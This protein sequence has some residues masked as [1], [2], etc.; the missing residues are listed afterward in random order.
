[1]INRR[2]KKQ[3]YPHQQQKTPQYP[4]SSSSAPPPPELAAFSLA[5]AIQEARTT[6]LPQQQQQQQRSKSNRVILPFFQRNKNPSQASL[7]TNTSFATA[8]DHIRTSSE[9]Q[10]I[11]PSAV[12]Y[13]VDSSDEETQ[14]E[15]LTFGNDPLS[16]LSRTI[17]VT[18][19]PTE[20]SFFD[21]NPEET[22]TNTSI[23]MST[24]VDPTPVPEA[25][26]AAITTEE[27]FVETSTDTEP[28]FD[29][30]QH[31]YSH[32]KGIW[33]WGKTIPV[34]SNVLTLTETSTAKVLDLTIHMDLPAIDQDVVSPHAKK[35]DDIVITPAI[36]A[37]WGIISPAVVKGEEMIVKPVL[38]EV[39]PR[40]LGPLGFLKEKK[41]EVVMEEKKNEIDKSVNPEVV[42]V[43]LN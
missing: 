12:S 13:F 41:V 8:N 40:I 22:T 7:A 31:I 39:V 6:S 3:R 35:L 30:A 9:Q 20:I 21:N 33:A 38:S 10:N 23:I 25:T 18:T 42:P 36:C 16:V 34:L 26:P 19:K 28:H 43:A 11:T 15:S 27:T 17:D 14:D 32:T 1:M 24:V 29:V 37:V 5:A 2:Q 4:P